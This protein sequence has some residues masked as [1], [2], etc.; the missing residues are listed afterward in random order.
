MKKT[1]TAGL[2]VAKERPMV[3]MVAKIKRNNKSTRLPN[4]SINFGADKNKVMLP[5]A[6]R[7][8]RKLMTEGSKNLFRRE[9][10]T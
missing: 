6:P 8:K 3:L 9:E 2:V 10:F 7:I 1:A 5:K 4:F